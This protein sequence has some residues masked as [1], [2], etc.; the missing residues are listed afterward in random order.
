M[1]VGGGGGGGGGAGGC[2]DHPNVTYKV[3]RALET[4]LPTCNGY[5]A[6]RFMHF[7]STLH[8][9]VSPYTIW[10]LTEN[11]YRRPLDLQTKCTGNVA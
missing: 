2:Y 11:K 3:D 1:R 7:S 6:K 8:I 10:L 5:W 4:D 9:S